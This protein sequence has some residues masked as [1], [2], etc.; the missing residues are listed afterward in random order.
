MHIRVG[1]LASY[2]LHYIPVYQVHD[3]TAYALLIAHASRISPTG[4]LDYDREFRSRTP[5]QATWAILDGTRWA[6]YVNRPQLPAAPLPTLRRPTPSSSSSSSTPIN[7][8]PCFQ[9]N[10][11][12]GCSLGATCPRLHEC[13]KCRRGADHPSSSESCPKRRRREGPSTS[14]D[15]AAGTNLLLHSLPSLFGDGNSSILIANNLASNFSFFPEEEGQSPTATNHMDTNFCK[16][17][18]SRSNFLSQTSVAVSQVVS[19]D[20]S[21]LIAPSFCKNSYPF[22][23][24]IPVESVCPFNMSV[25]DELAA[26]FPSILRRDY[27]S[28]GL[29]HGFSL[30]YV[31][32]PLISAKENN[33]SARDHP[34][35]I[36]KYLENELSHRSI[37]GPFS[38][39]PITNLHF[40]RF[41]VIPK[42]EPNKFRL[43]LDLSHP[44][45]ASVN[46]GIPDECATVSYTRLDHI[47]EKIV[48]FGKGTL[49]GKWDVSRAYRNIPVQDSDRA[50]LGM[51]WEGKIFVDLTLSFGGRSCPAI[52]TEVADVLA[53]ICSVGLNFTELDHYLDDFISICRNRC[54]SI[55]RE[56]F[57]AM[58]R[59]LGILKV[60]VADDKTVLPTTVIEFIGIILDSINLEAR[61]S[62]EKLRDFSELLLSW[63]NKRSCVKRELLSIIG[64]LSYAC[65]VVPYGR[66]FLRRLIDKASSVKSLNNRVHLS[67]S[68]REDLSWWLDLL[69][70][71]N[72][73]SMFTVLEWE[74]LPDFELTSDAAKSLGFGIVFG[75]EWCYSA[76]PSKMD[77]QINIAVLELVPV[78]LAASLWGKFWQR[79]KILFHID[80]KAVVDSLNSGLPKD[81]H[82][83]FL[84]RKLSIYA[85]KFSFRFKAV[86]I[87]GK[88]NIAADALSRLDLAL[89][90]DTCPGANEN[91][92]CVS[93]LAVRELLWIPTV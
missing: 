89:F 4:W 55:A 40:S 76:W 23:P 51:R 52:F 54:V 12:E 81:R 56:E 35:V 61:L 69:N 64:K 57:L 80:N 88:V 82:L 41:G 34:E 90:R 19:I 93:D 32:G 73:V 44:L 33:K 21:D 84:V 58:L 9:W 60:P 53:F 91:P 62:K 14:T 27:V 71:W 2:Y 70:N 11:P 28:N 39:P 77:P 92:I 45:N 10:K 66:P 1:F 42:K 50:L 65:Q 72:G 75:N 47:I 37:A 83:A 17:F 86:H 85:M 79:K 87:P 16:S 43:I 3:L 25:W 8:Q 59:T 20:R 13:K 48:R 22:N 68:D 7:Q 6:L 36:R 63:R 26:N 30:G 38:T 5:L 78:V 49:L 31:P 29:K 67:S 18:T 46:A 74:Y 24:L 15:S